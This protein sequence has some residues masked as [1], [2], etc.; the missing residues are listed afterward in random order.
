MK[1]EDNS[2]PPYEN[3]ILYGSERLSYET[4]KR[5]IAKIIHIYLKSH[6]DLKKEH[7]C[8]YNKAVELI[9][10]GIL[11]VDTST[12]KKAREEICEMLADSQ[13]KELGKNISAE[14]AMKS[15]I[16]KFEALK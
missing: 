7:L 16:E 5:E 9:G 1:L 13:I 8:A 11:I 12:S 10:K 3:A 6:P 2:P 14:F 4:V 15:I